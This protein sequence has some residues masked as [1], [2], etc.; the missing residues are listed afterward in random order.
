MDK[1]NFP[2]LTLNKE[3]T[4]PPLITS[5]DIKEKTKGMNFPINFSVG[6]IEKTLEE[7]DFF[8]EGTLIPLETESNIPVTIEVAGVKV[9]TGVIVITQDNDVFVRVL[10]NT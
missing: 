9:G 2:D 1:F 8:K 6:K 4:P 10:K 5:Y 7:V 3:Q